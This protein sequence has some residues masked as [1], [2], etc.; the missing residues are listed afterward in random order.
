M[1]TLSTRE[2]PEAS[3]PDSEVVKRVLEGETELFEILMRRYNQRLY[4][5]ARA[6][7]GDE[8]EAEQVMEDAHFQAYT[9]LSQFAE[10]SKFSTWL[11]KI[12][13]NEAL[14]RLRRRA[15]FVDFDSLAESGKGKLMLISSERTPEQKALNSELKSLL[16]SAVDNLPEHYRAVLIMRDV[17]GLDTSETSECLGIS[18]ETVKTRLHRARAMMRKQLLARA[19]VTRQ[20]LFSFQNTRCDKVVAAVFKRIQSYLHLSTGD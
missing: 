13:V 12:A 11:T 3:I 1:I 16:E 18:E 6:I 7:L 5:A 10:K 20:E 15:R 9:H 17:E 19:G 2:I 14:S 8:A 4:R